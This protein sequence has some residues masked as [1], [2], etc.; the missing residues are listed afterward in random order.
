MSRSNSESEFKKAEKLFGLNSHVSLPRSQ[1][2]GNRRNSS[3]QKSHNAAAQ[4]DWAGYEITLK[5]PETEM[6]VLDIT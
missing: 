3:I 1:T 5:E 4:T 6:V 2:H